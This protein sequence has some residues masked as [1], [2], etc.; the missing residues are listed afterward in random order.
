MTTPRIQQATPRSRAWAPEP[1]RSRVRPW[2]EALLLFAVIV[3][4]GVNEVR[5]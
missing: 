4:C 2:L 3:A 5:W 1:A